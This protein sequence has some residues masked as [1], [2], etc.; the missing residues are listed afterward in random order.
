MIVLVEN[1]CLVSPPPRPPTPS[2][3]PPLPFPAPTSSPQALY[4][5]APVPV[6]PALGDEAV[7]GRPVAETRPPPSTASSPTPPL[8]N[9]CPS[10]PRGQ[11]RV[12]PPEPFRQPWNRTDCGR[13]NCSA[14]FLLR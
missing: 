8:L 2:T 1:H 7:T 9:F 11:G 4:P 10:S 13:R 14:S 6:E 3:P 5:P 12:R